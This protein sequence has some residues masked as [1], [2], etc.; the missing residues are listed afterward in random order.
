VTVLTQHYDNARTGAYLQET[1]LSPA[2][3]NRNR[4]GHLFD[5]PVD[6]E[7][8]AQPLFAPQVTFGQ[9]VHNALY[10][11]TMH[12]RVYAFDADTGG[13]PLWTA[14]LGPFIPLPDPGIGPGG[15]RDISHAVGVLSTPVISTANHT[16]YVLAATKEGG[17]YFHRLH[18]LDLSTGAEKFGGPVTV[19]GGGFVSNLQNQRP[20]LL[21]AG[22]TVYAAFA[23]YGDRQPYHGYV[24]GF[25]AN[26]LQPRGVF[27][28]TPTG[29]MGGIWM[30]GQGPAADAAGNVYVMTGN[31]TFASTAITDKLT[32]GET[33][34][35]GPALADLGGAAMGLA[36]TGTDEQHMLNVI[37]ASASEALTDK[38]TLTE[39]AAVVGKTTFGES[40]T[41]APAIAD[42]GSSLALAWTGTDPN[43]SLNVMRTDLSG[44]GSGKVTLSQTSLDG[45][46]LAF[47]AGTAFLGWTGNDPDHHLNVATST[48]LATFSAPATLPET[49]LMAPAL[50][51]GAGRLFLAWTGN[52][53]RLNVLSSTDGITF[54]NKVTLAETASSA[55]ALSYLGGVLYL[56]WPG[57]DPGHSLNIL[58]STDGITFTGKVT[59]AETSDF[60]PALVESGGLR[61]AWTGRDS[62][63]SLNLLSGP[64]AGALGTKA[65]FGDTSA[66]A[67]GLA[68]S[69]GR[70]FL[71][72]TGRDPQARINLASLQ[73]RTFTSIDGPALAFGA[74]TGFLGWTGTDAAHHLNV[75]PSTDLRTF[76]TTVTL[77][78]TSTAGPALAYGNG[79]LF[80]GWTG[81]DGRLNM[82]SSTDGITFTNKVTLAETSATRPALSFAGGVL[83]LLW[84]G[85]DANHSLN[86]LQST[87]GIT[88]TGKVTLADS[89]DFHP[90]LARDTALRLAWTG[91]DAGRS[92]NLLSGG[93]PG[94][95]GDK[96][97]FGD[98]AQAGPALLTFA[99]ALWISWTGTDAGAHLNLAKI[100]EGGG[101]INLG[102]SFV[103]LAPDLSVADWFTPWNQAVLNQNDTDLGSGGALVLPGTRLL[104]GGGKEGKLYV[105]DTANMGHFCATCGESAG[106][107]QIV[108]WFPAATGR[109]GSMTLPAA[110]NS[111]GL[112][113]IH[114]SPVYWR[115]ASRGP[116]IFVWGEA[117]WLRAFQFTGSRFDA[118]PV[119]ISADD[120]H[121]PGASMPGGMLTV[122]AN[123]NAD[124]SGIIWATH[125]VSGDANQSEVA[126]LL[127]AVA[128]S[129]LSHEL[130]NSRPGYTAA[131]TT[132]AGDEVGTCAKLTPPT[133]VNGKVYVA[134]F[135][136]RVRVYGLVR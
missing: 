1:A 36:W 25:D 41:G 90:A 134:T 17:G 111:G 40:A 6:G 56:T 106:D 88:F 53:G 102:D 50:A 72:W 28:S 113:H 116:R 123:G 91:R 15:Y 45:P 86:V 109:K 100:S 122:S 133:V 119:D 22:T 105:L 3:V 8:Y 23:S 68:V 39:Q 57:T 38:V 124:D 35:G 120:V 85:T 112:H 101:Q 92:L 84:S 115:M 11:A 67:P 107:T 33:A 78:E 16:I 89:S 135:N 34:L 44:V 94:A 128:A 75:A 69:A 95:L 127:R 80:L 77:T 64:A 81:T 51:Y 61:L 32:L 73:F 47:G 104:V 9:S 103:K 65:T 98:S 27:N 19:Q 74:G 129:D 10:V 21:L 20:G 58:Q 97:T 2:T 79:R 93:S 83:Y 46:A 76:P 12:N 24:F 26:T 96:A 66:A 99:G 126:G 42:L 114:G 5:L 29:I 118:N 37:R 52:D 31:G 136:N 30:G 108:Q 87:D 62:N 14:V 63:Q 121:T 54:T 18:A 70:V 132:D 59:L 110:P 82:L 60:H 55:P 71:T 43:H 48:D 49:S 13:G 125:P 130:W 7:V 117:D 4:F 131:S